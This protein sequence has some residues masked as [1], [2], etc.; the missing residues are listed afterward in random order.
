MKHYIC[1][2]TYSQRKKKIPLM[3]KSD[4]HVLYHITS[5]IL[6]LPMEGKNFGIFISDDVNF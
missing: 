5:Q 1:S 3:D 4:N 2:N 6:H